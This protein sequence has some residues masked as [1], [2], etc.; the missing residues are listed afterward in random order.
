MTLEGPPAGPVG[1]VE[2]L[3]VGR[4]FRLEDRF[5][6]AAGDA[7]RTTEVSVVRDLGN[8]QLGP[9][10]GHVGMVPGDPGE[11]PPVRRQTRRCVEIRT[12]SEERRLGKEVVSKCKSGGA[13]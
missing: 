8:P 4:P 9:V 6:G 12:R 1:N 5:A 3:A 13:T 11:P 2:Q 10:P 7:P